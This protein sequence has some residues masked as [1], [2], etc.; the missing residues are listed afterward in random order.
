VLFGEGNVG[1][2]TEVATITGGK[3]FDARTGALADAFTDIRGYQ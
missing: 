1:E 3:T 2:M